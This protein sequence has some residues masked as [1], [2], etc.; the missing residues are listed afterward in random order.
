MEKVPV[1]KVRLVRESTELVPDTQITHAGA[2][3]ATAQALLQEEDREVFLVLF[4]NARSK[5]NGAHVVSVGDLDSSIVHPREVFKAAILAGASR[6]VC[7]HNHPSGD[8]GPSPEDIAVTQRLKEAGKLLGIELLDHVIIASD[9]RHVS[10]RE[11]GL[12]G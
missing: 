5:V 8:P 12:I 2:I 10:L 9:G 7:A 6:I 3:V 4:L 1:Y 11:R